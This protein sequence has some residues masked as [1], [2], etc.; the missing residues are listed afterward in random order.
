MIA[1]FGLILSFILGSSLTIIWSLPFIMLYL[2]GL[3]L[4]KI[5]NK[6][7]IPLIFSRIGKNASII[8]DSNPRGWIWGRY[9]IGYILEESGGGQGGPIKTLSIFI[10]CTDKFFTDLIDPNKKIETEINKDDNCKVDNCKVDKNKIK[11]YER[12]G[13]YFWLNYSNRMLD[14]SKYQPRNT[15]QQIINSIKDEYKKYNNVVSIISGE[16]GCGKSMISI[17]LAKEMNGTLCD[18][19]NPTD[20]GDDISIIYN[21]IMPSFEN[22]FILVLEEFDIIL[23]RVHNNLIQPHKHIPIQIRDKASW[24]LFMDRINR[25]FFPNMVVLLL[26]NPNP[27]MIDNLDKSY[28]REGRVNSR[29][30]ML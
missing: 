10:L 14:V 19:F 27:S 1:T 13:N 18:T 4:H 25:G 16:P 6:R 26:C 11:I 7:Q 8:E 22:P 24:N 21:T 28:L 20:P 12:N 3:R 2:C 23:I 5:I 30:H 17:L 15:Q 29:Y 9:Y